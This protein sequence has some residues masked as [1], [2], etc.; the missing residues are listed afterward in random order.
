MQLTII[1]LCRLVSVL[2]LLI[3]MT[4]CSGPQPLCHAS[5]G[6]NLNPAHCLQAVEQFKI[7]MKATFRSSHLAPTKRNQESK[8]YLFSDDP[9]ATGHELGPPIVFLPLLFTHQGCEIVIKMPVT[10][11][12]SAVW[13]TWSSVNRAILNSVWVTLTT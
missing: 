8:I 10:P 3:P 11:M 2:M 6:H 12:E 5:L 9:T 13:T 7:Y 4:T 1:I